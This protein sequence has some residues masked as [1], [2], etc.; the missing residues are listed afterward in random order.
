MIPTALV[1]NVYKYYLAEVIG[2][3]VKFQVDYIYTCIY[4]YAYFTVVV[5]HN[6]RF[7]CMLLAFGHQFYDAITR[8]HEQW[9]TQ[10]FLMEICERR[11]T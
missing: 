6:S 7:V 8:H 9:A 5:M 1:L 10:W 4:T 11:G 2:E 3:K